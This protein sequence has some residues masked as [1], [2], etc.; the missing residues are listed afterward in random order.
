MLALYLTIYDVLANQIKYQKFDLYNV[1]I[2]E[3]KNSTCAN[4]LEMPESSM[5]IIFFRTLAT[6]EHT[7]MLKLAH[8]T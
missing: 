6:R 2:I 1:N 8:D 3:E 4:R 5:V 7:F